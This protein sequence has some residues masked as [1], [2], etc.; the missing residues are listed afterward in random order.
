MCAFV[1]LGLNFM[2]KALSIELYNSRFNEKTVNL[3]VLVSKGIEESYFLFLLELRKA[4][5]K[6]SSRTKLFKK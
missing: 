5:W 6:A 2:S 1:D 3:V 4:F